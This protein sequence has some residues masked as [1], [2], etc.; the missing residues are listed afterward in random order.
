MCPKYEDHNINVYVGMVNQWRLFGRKGIAFVSLSGVKLYD[1]E[2]V[3]L[4]IKGIIIIILM[5]MLEIIYTLTSL[6]S[7]MWQP[8]CM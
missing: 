1:V 8:K 2:T 6:I 4:S 5:M 3:T 7:C